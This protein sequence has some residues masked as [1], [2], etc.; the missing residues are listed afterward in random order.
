MERVNVQYFPVRRVSGDGNIVETTSPQ[1][2]GHA[3][4]LDES[5]EDYTEYL[6]TIPADEALLAI[7]DEMAK[8]LTGQ[9][10]AGTN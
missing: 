7:G 5:D 9:I 6:F 2:K 4:L 8:E 1:R 3:R 10:P